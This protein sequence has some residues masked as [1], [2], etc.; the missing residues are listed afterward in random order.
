MSTSITAQCTTFYEQIKQCKELDLRD[1]RGEK[2]PLAI[3]LIGFMIALLR[4]CRTVLLNLLYQLKPKKMKA[5]IEEFADNF[6]ILL[7][8]LTQINFL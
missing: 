6:Q 8:W 2:H 4:T 3:I 7:Q 1:E 5:K